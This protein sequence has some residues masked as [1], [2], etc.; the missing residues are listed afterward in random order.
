MILLMG[1]KI[2]PMLDF[3]S[4]EDSLFKPRNEGIII[5]WILS[6]GIFFI[7]WFKDLRALVLTSVS[8]S[9]IRLL[10]VFTSS[11]LRLLP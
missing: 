9:L 2:H 7:T 3:T 11:S 4:F 8:L 1:P 10:R 5:D 6:A